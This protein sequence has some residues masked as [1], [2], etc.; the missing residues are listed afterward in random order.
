[1][2]PVWRIS[3]ISASKVGGQGSLARRG[4]GKY[5]GHTRRV[6]GYLVNDVAGQRLNPGADI[7]LLHDELLSAGNGEDTFMKAL[8]QRLEGTLEGAAESDIKVEADPNRQYAMKYL[9]I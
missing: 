1:M 3:I 6:A 8:Q 4:N 2:Q 9:D 5:C 7:R